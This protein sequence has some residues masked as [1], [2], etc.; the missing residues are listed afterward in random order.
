MVIADFANP[1]PV[2]EARWRFLADRVMGGVSRGSAVVEGV[3]GHR[4]LHLRGKV[5]LDRGGGFIQ[6]V[7][8]L[9]EERGSP[10]D[11][12]DHSGL[13][14]LVRGVPG[15]YFLHLRTSHTRA[16]WQYYGAP[17]PVEREWRFV[18]LIWSDFVAQ[19]TSHPLDPSALIRVGLVAAWAS[20]EADVALAHL[21]LLPRGP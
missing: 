9:G 6:V 19:S 15:K 13:G 18:K 16:P 20:F 2:E 21:T 4:A 12:S 10:L 3:E 5:S 7:R 14:A 17:L 8:G 11:A 1:D